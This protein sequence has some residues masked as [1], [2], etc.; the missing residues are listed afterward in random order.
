M[1]IGLD[2]PHLLEGGLSLCREFPER[3]L[4]LQA[5]LA[6]LFAHIAPETVHLGHNGCGL[7]LGVEPG[8]QAVHLLA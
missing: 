2:N 6:E 3:A 1:Q 4:D 7:G 5:G 8:L